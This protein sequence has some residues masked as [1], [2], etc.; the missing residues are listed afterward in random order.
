MCDISA[1]A[2]ADFHVDVNCLMWAQRVILSRIVIHLTSMCDTS[3]YLIPVTSIWSSSY[4]LSPSPTWIR[5]THLWREAEDLLE[6]TL[7][8]FVSQSSI[9][10]TFIT[11]TKDERPLTWPFLAR[12]PRKESKSIL[13]SA[14]TSFIISA[15]S[16]F[17]GVRPR[18][19]R[20]DPSSFVVTLPV[21]EQHTIINLPSAIVVCGLNDC[22]NTLTDTS[23][24]SCL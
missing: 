18:D 16:A 15:T 3:Y 7:H 12:K 8:G 22:V 4:G 6:S 14:G 23:I 21:W 2:H 13:P 24:Q 19:R 10:F 1:S 9:Y 11:Q 17:V 5:L 20:S